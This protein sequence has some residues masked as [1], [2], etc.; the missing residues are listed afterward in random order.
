MSKY[1]STVETAFSLISA[2]ILNAIQEAKIVDHDAY[3]IK[4]IK[5]LSEDLGEVY[6]PPSPDRMIDLLDS[7]H[8][9]S[10]LVRGNFLI[11]RKA[12]SL[13]KFIRLDSQKVHEM[14]QDKD[15]DAGIPQ[16][17]YDNLL[18]IIQIKS[19][20][21]KLSEWIVV[22]DYCATRVYLGTDPS[23]P[24]NRVAF[25]EKTPRVRM[26]E[27]IDDNKE[28]HNWFSG[29]KGSGGSGGSEGHIPENELYGFYPKSRE[30]CDE[31]LKNL[32]YDF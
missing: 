25:I 23:N 30:W 14:E 16:E 29:P 5:K 1:L 26:T 32:G 22:D 28:R 13:G 31:T 19:E 18:E 11:G 6:S 15:Y 20:R 17:E 12:H 10:T 3:S 27:F 8:N 7:I 9:V 21:N 4:Y 24:I 2:E